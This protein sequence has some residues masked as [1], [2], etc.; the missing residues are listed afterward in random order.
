MFTYH[1]QCDEIKDETGGARSR[2]WGYENLQKI[3]VKKSEL[4]GPLGKCI[5]RWGDII[6]GLKQIISEGL[7]WIHSLITG[8]TE[9][10]QTSVTNLGR[11]SYAPEYQLFKNDCTKFEVLIMMPMGIHPQPRRPTSPRLQCIRNWLAGWSVPLIRLV[12]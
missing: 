4:K 9:Q 10:L 11:I 1:N 2:Y 6:R 7:N 5:L 12:A 8:P 3:K